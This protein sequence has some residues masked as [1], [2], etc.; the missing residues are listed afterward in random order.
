MEDPAKCSNSRVNVDVFLGKYRV[1]FIFQILMFL[2]IWYPF[3]PYTFI[4]RFCLICN[5]VITLLCNDSLFLCDCPAKIFVR[6]DLHIM[7]KNELSEMEVRKL[8]VKLGTSTKLAWNKYFKCDQYS[9]RKGGT[10]F[11]EQS[12]MKPD[13]S[14]SGDSNHGEM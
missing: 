5:Y 6:T 8:K 7:F 9:C 12:E 1:E 13:T 4:R 11:T 14:P 2:E 3:L 10:R